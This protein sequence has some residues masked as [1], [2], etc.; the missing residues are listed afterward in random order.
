MLKNKNQREGNSG[1]ESGIWY[2]CRYNWTMFYQTSSLHSLLIALNV[3][4]KL[5]CL[6]EISWT[7][8][9]KT[10]LTSFPCHFLFSLC[11]YRCTYMILVFEVKILICIFFHIIFSYNILFLLLRRSISNIC[12]TVFLQFATLFC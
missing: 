12:F 3:N 4:V 10:S 6:R 5:S 8:L 1:W 7:R 2:C 9:I 11:T